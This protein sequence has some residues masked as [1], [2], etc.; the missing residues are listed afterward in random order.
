MPSQVVGDSASTG[1]HSDSYSYV[2]LKL[3]ELSL[4]RALVVI[5]SP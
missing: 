2:E 1:L 5:F 3:H 4:G